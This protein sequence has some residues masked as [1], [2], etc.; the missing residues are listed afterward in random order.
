MRE[1]VQHRRCSQLERP[2]HYP[3]MTCDQHRE[4]TIVVRDSK[5]GAQL[6][7]ALHALHLVTGVAWPFHARRVGL[8]QIVNQRR[9]THGCKRRKRGRHLYD[10]ERVY[11]GVDF[12]MPLLRLWHT[13]QGLELR[14][15][16]CECA[17]QSRSTAKTPAAIL[18]QVRAASP[19]THV[20][21]PVP[22]VRRCCSS[23]ASKRGVV[24]DAKF[25][26]AKRA[27]KR[28]TRSTRSGSSAKAGETW[29]SCRASRSRWPP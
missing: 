9:E 20:P 3:V 19:A 14:K 28:A 6:L 11:P 29:R 10:H 22:P 1:Q 4:I 25:S 27:A 26:A 15:Y 24:G 18:L 13:E 2:M 12:R 5:P 16:L 21:A 8:A 7:H 17:P 23:A